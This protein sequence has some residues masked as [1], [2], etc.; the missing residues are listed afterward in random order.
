MVS[1]PPAEARAQAKALFDLTDQ[2]ALVVGAGAGGLGEQAALALASHGATVAVADLEPNLAALQGIASSCGPGSTAHA[3]DVTSEQSVRAL[4][5]AVVAS[6]GRI[7]IVV[8]TAGVMLRRAFDETSV[9]D[10]SSEPG[11]ER[12]VVAAWC[13]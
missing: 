7:D 12:P 11:C 6:H 1:A 13:S 10:A 4:G 2:V 9:E 8:N 3:V 5:D